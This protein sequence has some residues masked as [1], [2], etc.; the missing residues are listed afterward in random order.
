MTR[1]PR[2]KTVSVPSIGSKAVQRHCPRPEYGRDYVSVPSIGSKAVQ[3]SPPRRP[4]ANS[5]CFSTLYRVEGCAA[6]D[7]RNH[8]PHDRQFQYPLSGRRLCST[9]ETTTVDAAPT[10]FS[11]LYRV[12]GCAANGAG[13]V[14]DSQTQFQYPLSGR[15][16]CSIDRRAGFDGADFVSVPSI[17]S[18]AVQQYISCSCV[19]E[20]T[21]SVPSIG[22][23]AVQ[24]ILVSDRGYIGRG[25]QYPL[26]GRR[27]CSGQPGSIA[28]SN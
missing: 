7:N 23:K 3:Q 5:S 10:G 14:G 4:T 26:S 1:R 6:H 13:H 20:P 24:P 25:F 19:S 15:R 9:I 12:E 21:V 28:K 11:T 2:S 22:S 18:K 27:L 17:G 16:L 8:Q